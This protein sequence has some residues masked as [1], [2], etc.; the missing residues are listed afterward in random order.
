MQNYVS[1]KEAG[2][3][4]V[5]EPAICGNGMDVCYAA[6]E[7]LG[8]KVKEEEIITTSA[9]SAGEEAAA[10]AANCAKQK[11]K[12]PSRTL[13]NSV[14]VARCSSCCQNATAREPAT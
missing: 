14:S 3:R 8:Y 11:P 7:Q 5:R 9:K 4:T 1:K 6:F 13:C 12:F 10:W 2:R